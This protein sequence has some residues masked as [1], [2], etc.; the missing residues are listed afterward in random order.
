MSSIL[1]YFDNLC[2]LIP[3]LRGHWEIIYTL[4]IYVGSI[5]GVG[6]EGRPHAPSPTFSEHYTFSVTQIQVGSSSH[7]I[8]L[9]FISSLKNS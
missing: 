4:S 6:I 1:L 9:N 5:S 7:V 3:S 2:Y 8:S